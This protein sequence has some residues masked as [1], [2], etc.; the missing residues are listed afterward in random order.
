MVDSIRQVE[1][2]LGLP[3]K[4]AARSELKN[5][6][7]VRKSLVAKKKVARGEVF[8]EENLGIKRPGLGVEPFY[9]WHYLGQIAD[10]DYREDE[11]ILR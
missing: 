3:R 9:Y 4:L 10:R 7:L 6:P 2:A 5:L 11:E 8:T 1:L